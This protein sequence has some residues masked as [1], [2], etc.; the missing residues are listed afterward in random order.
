MYAN[1]GPT[2]NF[3]YVENFKVNFLHLFL[4]TLEK[5]IHE[6]GVASTQQIAIKGT[7]MSV[8]LYA[9]VLDH[10]YLILWYKGKYRLIELE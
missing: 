1:T 4:C 6:V 2:I 10:I 9:G 5:K 8:C 3:V 7:E